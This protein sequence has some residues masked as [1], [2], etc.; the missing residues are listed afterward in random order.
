MGIIWKRY[1]LLT[2]A[3]EFKQRMELSPKISNANLSKNPT[4]LEYEIFIC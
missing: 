3:P 4:C 1:W 2:L